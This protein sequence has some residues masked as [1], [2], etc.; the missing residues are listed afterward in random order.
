MI[1]RFRQRCMI[2]L[3]RLLRSF[4][5][6]RP[7]NIV[8]HVLTAANLILL[9]NFFSG[10]PVFLLNLGCL[11]SLNSRVNHLWMSC[12]AWHWRKFVWESIKIKLIVD[13]AR[14]GLK[15]LIVLK[16]RVFVVKT[17]MIYLIN[18]LLSSSLDAICVFFFHA[19]FF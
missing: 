16:T 4:R 13:S 17:R 15:S 12:A 19:V 2:C 18:Y 8:S 11:S 14:L 3:C 5:L 1:C 6:S 10:R 9:V 7:Q